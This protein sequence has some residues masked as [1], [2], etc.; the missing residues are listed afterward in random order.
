MYIAMNT[1]GDGF[2][3]SGWVGVCTQQWTQEVMDLGLGV[4]TCSGCRR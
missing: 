2:G 1:G 4:C 3:V